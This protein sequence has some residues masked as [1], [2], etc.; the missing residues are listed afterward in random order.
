VG[1]FKKRL[2]GM[3]KAWATG[4]DSAPGVPGAS[5]TM[6]LQSAKVR[7]SKSSKKLMIVREHLVVE[8]EYQGEVVRDNMMLETDKGPFY[9]AKWIRQMGYDVPDDMSDLEEVL[10]AMSDANPIYSAEVTKSG[11]FTNA[12]VDELLQEEA[13]MTTTADDAGEGAEPTAE[14]AE[15]AEGAEE[16]WSVGDVASFSDDDGN[17][18]AGQITQIDEGE[19]EA[20]VDVDGEVYAVPLSELSA[21]EE[22]AELVGLLAFASAQGVESVT[23][24]MGKEAVIEALNEYEWKEAEITADEAALLTATGVEF[25]AKPAAKKVIKKATKKA[26][27]KTTKTV[28]KKTTKKVVKKGGK[29]K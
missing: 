26:A 17:E 13:E 18:Y 11:D 22:D 29:R 3:Q 2:N 19:E 7:E 23:D 9:A 6:Q 27:K 24:E 16:G 1:E 10:S 21:E 25:V 12:N 5:Y 4:K 15:G 28:A 8:G 20:H 14:A